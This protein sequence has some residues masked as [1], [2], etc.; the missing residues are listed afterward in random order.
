MRNM[1]SVEVT[2]REIHRVLKKG[3]RALILELGR[4]HHPVLRRLHRIWLVS[5]VKVIGIF[6]RGRKEPF[7]YLAASIYEFVEPGRFLE[8]LRKCG[9]SRVRYRPLQNGIA[10]IYIGVK[11]AA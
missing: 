10:G 8:D 1:E 2:L 7:D 3:G 5:F 4:P 9:F 11:D 6:L